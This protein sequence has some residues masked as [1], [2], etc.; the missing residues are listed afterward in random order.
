MSATPIGQ[1]YTEPNSAYYLDQV[2]RWVA[3][4]KAGK[5]SSNAYTPSYDIL[6]S[7]SVTVTDAASTSSAA[8]GTFDVLDDRT[9][10]PL[11]LNFNYDYIDKSGNNNAPT[12]TG[13][14]TYVTGP[15]PWRTFAQTPHAFSFDG[16]SYIT[17]N[18]TPFDFERTDLFS[19]NFWHKQTAKAAV[20]ALVSKRTADA[21]GTVGWSITTDTSGFMH[22]RL[23]AAASELDVRT[24]IDISDGI[25]RFFSFVYSGTSIPSGVVLKINDTTHTLTTVT[26]TLA[27]TILNNNNLVIGAHGVA[28]IVPSGTA[29]D[30]VQIWSVALSS[31]NQTRLAQF[32]QISHNASVTNPAYQSLYDLAA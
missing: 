9:T 4:N 19:V 28:N 20:Y 12:L 25:W 31:T 26:N 16:A 1:G 3:Q 22:F 18:D 32:R 7:D 21:A 10:Q 14:E 15:T 11:W 13:T 29:L 27:A 8:I 2:R 6:V 5:T 17:F 23:V 24:T 30:E